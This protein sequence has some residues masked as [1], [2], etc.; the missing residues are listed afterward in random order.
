MNIEHE[1]IREDNGS[2]FRTVNQ[3]IS[4]E[5]SSSPYHCHPEYELLCIVSGKGTRHVGNHTS[6]YEDGDLLLIG[7]GLAHAMTPLNSKIIHEQVI[8]Q[9]K[10]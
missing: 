6:N 8:V 9:F 7:P 2:S 4:A 1:F 5:K 10:T 3:K